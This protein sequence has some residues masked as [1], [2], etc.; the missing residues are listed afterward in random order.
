MTIKEKIAVMSAFDRG[1]KVQLKPIR[2]DPSGWEDATCPN[3]N[4]ESFEYRIKP[5]EPRVI[6]VPLDENGN[7]IKPSGY[8]SGSI[9]GFVGK[10]RDYL[11]TLKF[12]EVIE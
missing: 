1:E 6:Y 7:M 4:W 3:F 9:I 11:K 2:D 5:R 10:R 12:I 8:D